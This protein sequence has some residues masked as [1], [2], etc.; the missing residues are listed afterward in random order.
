MSAPAEQLVE[1]VD[2]DGRVLGIVPRGRIR[3]ENLLHRSV[4]VV[5]RAP[6]GD[7]LVHRRAGWKDVWPGYWDLAVGGVVAVA[8]PWPAAARRELAEEVGVEAVELEELGRFTYRD[9]QVAELGRVYLVVG[10]G[11]F[12]FQD[13]EVSEVAWV[14]PGRLR[15]WASE[16]AVCPDSLAGVLPLLPFV[17]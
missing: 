8:E 15:G 17:P 2:E 7:V 4:F 16:R 1:W 10:D 14:A 5:V 9:G 11:P 3:A 12:R 6:W 13:G